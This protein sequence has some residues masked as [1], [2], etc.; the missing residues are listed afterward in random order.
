MRPL[1]I[2]HA[3]AAGEAPANTL[4]GVRAALASADAMENDV[5]LTADRGVLDAVRYHSI[6]LAE[7]DMA[8]RIL[9]CADYLEP[10]RKQAREWRADLASRL[11]SAP[12]QVIRQV[13]TARVGHLVS[14]GRP[15]LEPTVR[16][17]NS[18][19]ADS[20]GSA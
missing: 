18:L 10:G 3:A 9:Y 2:A 8:G 19:V 6:G 14:S 16:F 12:T 1:V 20:S 15:L 4:A 11:P 13:A 7:W 5:Q 17:W